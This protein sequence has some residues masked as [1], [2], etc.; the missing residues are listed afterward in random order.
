MNRR[1]FLKSIVPSVVK[2]KANG[3][4]PATEE[5]KPGVSLFTYR[6]YLFTTRPFL[7]GYIL[8]L[9]VDSDPE[10]ELMVTLPF[11]SLQ[12]RNINCESRIRRWREPNIRI[13]TN[14][15][16]AA[17]CRNQENC[18]LC[19]FNSS[20]DDDCLIDNYNIYI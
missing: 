7:W 9:Q 19:D 11:S 8:S 20:S 6:G 17:Y 5:E 1:N 14:E 10:H 2:V 16:K 3:T 13:A 4:R 15:H 12:D 18:V